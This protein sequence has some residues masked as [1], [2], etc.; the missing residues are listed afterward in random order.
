MIRK[1]L[2]SIVL[3]FEVVLALGVIYVNYFLWAMLI[4]VN[5][6]YVYDENEVQFF[7]ISN[8]I[9]TDICL[10]VKSEVIDWSSFIL[11]QDFD[12]VY[13]MPAYIGI[14]WG[15]KG[16]YLDTPRWA[17]LK[18]STA[19]N[20]IFLPSE[21]AMHVTYY[22]QEP[23][24]SSNVVRCSMSREEYMRLI[25]YVQASFNGRGNNVQAQL[26]PGKGYSLKDN[27]YQATGSYWGLRTCNSWT[28]EALK[29]AGVKTSLHALF[30]PAVMRWIH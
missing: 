8:G 29:V 5:T 20:A 15:D 19:L 10:P 13:E 6:E 24:E 28:N 30:E 2:K 7:V 17:D 22:S 4:P 18:M 16:F 26:I 23:E 25:E 9:H 27:F 14:G 12:G 11:V 3:S 1:V 21:T